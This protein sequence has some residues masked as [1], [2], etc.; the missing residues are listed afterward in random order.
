MNELAKRLR[1]LLQELSASYDSDEQLIVAQDKLNL[2]LKRFLKDRSDYKERLDSINI[3]NI[4]SDNE[5]TN[6]KNSFKSLI[7]TI[8]EDIE[9]SEIDSNNED[10]LNNDIN[11]TRKE[12]EIEREKIQNE[13]YKIKEI[14]EEILVDREKL[15]IEQEKFNEFK[16]KLEI[17]D[18]KLDF[19]FNAMIHKRNAYIWA[20]LAG[21]LV[22]ILIFILFRNIDINDTF[23]S[24]GKTIDFGFK[25]IKNKDSNMINSAIYFSFSKYIFTRLFLYSILIYTIVFCI[26]NYNAQMHN[27]I[28]NTHKSNAFKSVISLLNTAKSDDGSD[29]ILIQA[30]QT[31]FSHQQTG[32]YS[33]DI[34]PNNPNLVTN[35][36]E[37]VAKKI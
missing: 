5:F 32:Y 25:D 37:S 10:S 6:S 2:Y 31:I 1:N 28:I 17:S 7:K 11:K 20:A 13:A 34:E 8:L 14:K 3:L 18:K 35:V 15:L 16:A 19:Q 26:K 36:I 27:Y 30:T 33:K 21:I 24:I 23:I 22:I 29:K 4:N 9:L 12:I